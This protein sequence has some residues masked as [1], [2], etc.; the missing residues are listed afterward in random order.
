MMPQLTINR[1]PSA[2]PAH[3]TSQH[4]GERNRMRAELRKLCMLA[5]GIVLVG[6]VT[7]YATERPMRPVHSHRTIHHRAVVHYD[8]FTAPTVGARAEVEPAVRPQPYPYNSHETDG[9]SRNPDDCAYGCVDN[10]G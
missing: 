8:A 4:R 7:A 6:P 9:L 1:S 3:S 2:A 10:G 5:L